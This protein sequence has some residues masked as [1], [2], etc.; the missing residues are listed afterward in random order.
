M[1][2]EGKMTYD[3]RIGWGHMIKEGEG[4]NIIKEGGRGR[5]RG[6]HIIKEEGDGGRH[7]IKEGG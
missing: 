5:R 2:G 7:I 6:R 4:R 1:G 3:S